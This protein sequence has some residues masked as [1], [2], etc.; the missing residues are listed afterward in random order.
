M[1]LEMGLTMG[2]T[3][4]HT[5][6]HL[7]LLDHAALVPHAAVSLENTIHLI[8][9]SAMQLAD[10]GSPAVAGVKQCVELV[11][12]HHRLPWVSFQACRSKSKT[13]EAHPQGRDNS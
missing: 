6:C 4:V 5:L 11:E 2:L 8:T 7:S 3:K 9:G 1:L 10:L 13:D 12:L